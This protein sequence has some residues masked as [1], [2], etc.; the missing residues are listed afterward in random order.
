MFALQLGM[1]DGLREVL[2]WSSPIGLAAFFIAVG[3]MFKL[4]GWGRP[5]EKK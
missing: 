3:I 2:G 5:G 4:T 1:F